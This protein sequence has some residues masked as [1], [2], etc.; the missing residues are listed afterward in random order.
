MKI[1]VIRHGQTD[2]NKEGR[3]QGH[4][5]ADLNE[6]GVALAEETAQHLQDVPFDL[7]FTSPALR[8]EHTAQIIL[9]NRII[10]VIEDNR[11]LEIG[12]GVWEGVPAFSKDAEIK[13]EPEVFK[14]FL[15]DPLSYVPPEGGESISDVLERTGDFLDEIL[16]EPAYQDKTIL[17]STHGCASRALMTR[18]YEEPDKFWQEGVPAN[19]AVSIIDV[20]NGVPKL[21]LKDHVYCTTDTDDM[22][23]K[24][25]L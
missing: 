5:G 24:Q 6:N 20:V 17:M 12:F 1:Y 19:C 11:L 10:P 14:G 13:F 23:A 25:K 4:S 3:L 16:K 18:M 22:W 8:A 2:W 7:C 15:R 9:N 21:T